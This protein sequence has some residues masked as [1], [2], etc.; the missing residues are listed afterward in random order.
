MISNV[1]ALQK[2]RLSH[3]M[4]LFCKKTKLFYVSVLQENLAVFPITDSVVCFWA[5]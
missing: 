5:C 3:F 2:T 4:Y 1:F